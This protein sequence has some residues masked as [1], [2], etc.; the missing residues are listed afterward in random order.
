MKQDR[1]DWLNERRK[2]IGG[3]DVAAIVGLSP[4]VTALDVYE[5]KLGLVPPVETTEA[6]YWGTMLEPAIRQAYS[7]RT[8]FAV[9]KP[10]KPFVHPKYTFMRANLDGLVINDN[11]IAEF[12]TASTSHGWGEPGTDEIP[13]YYLTQVQHYMAVTDKP[14][15]DVALLVAGRD[16]S[17]YTV[18]ADKEL[19]EQ[20]IEIEA[21]F[22]DKVQK[23]IPP[24]P[25]TYEEFQRIRKQKFPASGCLEADEEVIQTVR[26]YLQADDEEKAITARMG[27]L[28]KRIAELLGDN[29]AFMLN[30]KKLVSWRRGA[31]CKRLNQASLKTKYPDIFEE[32]ATVSVNSPSLAFSRK[33]LSA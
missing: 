27:E 1:T 20:L 15:C 2:G 18:E 6:M 8:G 5:Q 4:W 12:K 19:Q 32:F 22:W 28:K 24:E 9:E 13:E 16:F 23:H 3:S 30:G 21:E 7:D 14:V 10:E 17:V 29:N 26:E 11:R 33:L 25:A 31:S